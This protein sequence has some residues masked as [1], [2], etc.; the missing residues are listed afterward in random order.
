[1]LEQ[2]NAHLLSWLKK[3]VA[4]L[5]D[6]SPLLVLAIIFLTGVI[7]TRLSRKFK[8]PA[9]TGQIFGGIIIGHYVL[10]IFSDAAFHGF[11]PFTKFALGI[12]ALTIGSHF[13]FRKLHNSTARVLTIA[14]ADVIIV[15]TLTFIILRYVVQLNLSISLLV[16]AISTATAPGSIIHVVKEVRAKGIFT[17]TLLA[18]VALNN[19]FTI[20]LFFVILNIVIDKNLHGSL[21][22]GYDIIKAAIIILES[23]ITG[24]LAGWIVIYLTS[25]KNRNFSFITIV[26][27]VVILLI[28]FSETFSFSSVLAS[29]V[30]GI[31]IV[32]FSHHRQKIFNV[33]GDLEKDVFVLFF[34]LAGTHLDFEAI[35]LAGFAGISVIIIRSIG[36]FVG[37]YLG[38]VIYGAT[39]TIKRSIK[40]SMF[41]FAGIAIGLVLY[42]GA[43]PELSQ[44]ANEITAIV[45][46]AVV[47]FEI[48]GPFITKY[49][50]KLAG[51]EHKNRVRLLDFLQEEFISLDLQ[52]NNKWE[53]LEELV[54]F[55]HK[56]H[57][58]KEVSMQELK[59]RIVAREKEF[60]TGI[61]DNLAIP[62]VI[63]EGGPR[64]RGVIGISKSGVDFDSIDK[65]PVH[66]IVLIATPKSSYDLHLNALQSIAKIFG[67]HPEIKREI[68][69]CN[70][71]E[72]VFEILQKE[73]VEDLNPFFDED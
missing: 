44:Y 35:R 53:I 32:N 39:A 26:L 55:L 41:P 49:S 16:A 72:E 46:T 27:F 2:I 14:L 24:G 40:F 52:S 22:I 58:V 69:N 47:F 21:H 59:Q 62:H 28:G 63:I 7:F 15:P 37:P 33:F 56:T 13:D 43:I 36:K 19:I 61:G 73:D 5:P 8:I 10:N 64:I 50:I 11:A 51:E 57:N 18:V 30:F 4:L 12:I 48:L 70:S 45:L 9:I 42:V 17:K 65:Q 68:I 1:M 54:E 31:V 20:T 6:A 67:R 34:V 25:K 71:S 29:L 66:I 60:T 3:D 23:I 38:A